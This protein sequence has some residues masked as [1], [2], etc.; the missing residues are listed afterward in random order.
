M[1]CSY[2]AMIQNLKQTT[3]K[4]KKK[5]TEKHNMNHVARLNL[6]IIF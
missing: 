2:D 1:S 5:N 6:P 4:K 3:R